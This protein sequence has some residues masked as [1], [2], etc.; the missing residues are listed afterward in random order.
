MMHLFA[1]KRKLWFF[2]LNETKNH[3]LKKFKKNK[4][5]F[6]SFEVGLFAYK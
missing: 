4:I 6:S 3:P 2:C 5:Y 1:K